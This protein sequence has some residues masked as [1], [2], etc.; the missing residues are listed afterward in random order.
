[1]DGSVVEVPV[2]VSMFVAPAGCAAA[3]R[4]ARRRYHA[5]LE[6]AAGLED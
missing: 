1:M 3:E 2:L 5:R 6:A 4:L